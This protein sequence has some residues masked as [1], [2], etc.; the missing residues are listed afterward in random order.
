MVAPMLPAERSL[1][2]LLERATGRVHATDK[3][4]SRANSY[5]EVSLF[6]KLKPSVH[7]RDALFIT[8]YGK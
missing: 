8:S 7:L 6:F 2:K 1:A 5:E 4:S 3:A